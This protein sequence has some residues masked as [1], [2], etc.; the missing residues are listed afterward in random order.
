MSQATEAARPGS[1]QRQLEVLRH[2]GWG[3]PFRIFQPRN[4]CFWVLV[5]GYIGGLT[6][7]LQVI[8]PTAPAYSSGLGWGV[9]LFA[10][11]AV[12]WWLYLSHLN[13]YTT[14]P[15]K[16]IFAAFLWGFLAATFWIAIRANDAIL[17]IYAKAFGNAWAG[18]WGPALTAPFTE[19]TAKMLGLILLLGLVPQ[20]LRTPFDGFIIGAFIGL[21]FQI[22][23]D[24]LYGFQGATAQFGLNQG[25]LV[26]QVLLGRGLAGLFSHTMFSAIYCAGLMW[27]LNRDGSDHRLR[28][29]G[30][31]ALAT[32]F[33]LTW[34]S[35]GVYFNHLLSGAGSVILNYVLTIIVS[36]ITIRLL[37]RTVRQDERGWVRD[38]LQ[39]EVD[40]GV[41]TPAEVDVLSGGR[42]QRRKLLHSVHGHHTR[43]I[44]KHVIT[45]AEDLA[46]QIAHGGG[47]DTHAVIHARTEVA[48]V[49][50]GGQA[51]PFDA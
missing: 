35:G 9:I 2:S 28:G 12:P 25:S 11:Y 24:I 31:M 21:G 18:A 19:E 41:L 27:L 13:R 38:V 40:Q 34:D 3:V 29:L 43:Q 46:T 7:A 14:V 48:R 8:R 47:Q 45:A 42:K 49:R 26:G 17:T 44:V 20:V 4:L 5:L 15:H 16:I 36:L 51:Q 10:I 23:E 33:H 37:L 50:A 6:V 1:K 32:I 30:L 39:P 22:S